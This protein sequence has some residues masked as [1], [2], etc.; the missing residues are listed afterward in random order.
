MLAILLSNP[1]QQLLQQ[2]NQLLLAMNAALLV[3]V[4]YMVLERVLSNG[5]LLRNT[6]GILAASK[7]GKDFA[8]TLRQAK[9]RGKLAATLFDA[10]I[11]SRARQPGSIH[12]AQISWDDSSL[13]NALDCLVKSK[14]ANGIERVDTDNRKH[15]RHQTLGK[16]MSLGAQARGKKAQLGTDLNAR[17]VDGVTPRNS[18]QG[19]CLAPRCNCGKGKTHEQ[20]KHFTTRRE[21][22][23]RVPHKRWLVDKN[24]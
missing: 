11:I 20:T 17:I 12:L 16:K 10:R 3:N 18:R 15:G 7:Q 14:V 21:R 1:H 4:T 13:L 24:K 6:R 19:S 2:V 8:L 22:N 9:G 23:A 5:E